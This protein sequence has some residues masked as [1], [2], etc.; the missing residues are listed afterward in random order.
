MKW[1]VSV[2]LCA[3][4]VT[5]ALVAGRAEASH[6]D[7]P[8]QGW[9]RLKND[10]TAEDFQTCKDEKPKLRCLAS[11]ASEACQKAAQ[12]MY[13]LWVAKHHGKMP[14]PPPQPQPQ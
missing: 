1:N 2:I 9:H 3:W 5:L 8:P 10:C 14:P 4:V 13:A 11:K 6:K 12:D 7:G